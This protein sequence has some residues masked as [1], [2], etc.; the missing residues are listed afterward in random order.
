M[1]RLL[2]LFAIITALSSLPSKAQSDDGWFTGRLFAYDLITGDGSTFEIHYT[3]L[4]NFNNF[5]STG[6][7]TGVIFHDGINIPLTAEIRV[8][9]VEKKRIL[10]TFMMSAGYVCGY[11]MATIAPR[12]G[13]ETGRLARIR[14]AFDIGCQ[15]L[16]GQRCLLVGAGVLF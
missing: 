16:D 13:L 6:M 10:P 3:H 9:P 4:Y 14:Y 1:T 5:F 8:H 2:L 12:I 11:G 15:F 7:G